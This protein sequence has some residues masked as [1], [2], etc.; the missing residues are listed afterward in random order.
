MISPFYAPARIGIKK[1]FQVFLTGAESDAFQEIRDYLGYLNTETIR[2]A[3]RYLVDGSSVARRALGI[4]PRRAS[5]T[6][7][8]RRKYIVKPNP[9]EL[10]NV[11]DEGN[12]G[13][14]LHLDPINE[15][16]ALDHGLKAA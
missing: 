1:T 14:A 7:A 3:L 4:V 8:R 15:L 2:Y 9:G 16:H 13:G 6:P 10:S 11:V 5:R 12:S